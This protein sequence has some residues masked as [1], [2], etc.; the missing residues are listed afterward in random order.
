VVAQACL[1]LPN[2]PAFLETTTTDKNHHRPPANWS[3]YW[4]WRKWDF[5]TALSS[6]RVPAQSLTTHVLSAPLTIASHLLR[7]ADS[8]K[9]LSSTNEE[10]I[11]FRC[12]CV[13]ARAESMMPVEYWREVLLLWQ[14]NRKSKKRRRMVLSFVGPDIVRRSPMTLTYEENHSS[15]ELQWSYKGKFHDYALQGSSLE[16]NK[17]DDKEYDAFIFLNP[18]FG[19]PHLKEDWRP[20][21]DLL[22]RDSRTETGSSSTSTTS[23][24]EKIMLLTAHSRLDAD[25]DLACLQERFFVAGPNQHHSMNLQMSDYLDNPFASHIT[26][27]D[28]FDSQHLVQPNQYY[29]V[30][31][32]PRR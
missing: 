19:H 32:I 2:H 7:A 3:E 15:L 31:S 25:R 16:N 29:R 23:P 17:E 18:G 21:L 28:P 1:N 24:S 10:E 27:Q 22:F 14:Y 9:K 8:N 4:R 11:L 30:L 13:G 6:G 5:S 12:C 26:Y 20:T